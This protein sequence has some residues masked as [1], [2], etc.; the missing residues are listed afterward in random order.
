MQRIVTAELMDDPAAHRDE[1]ARSLAYIRG[2]NRLLG[3]TR[4]LLRHLHRW[5]QRWPKNR[6]ITLL[7]IGTGS[8]DIPLAARTWADQRGFDL[9]ITAVDLH[10]T[11]LDLAREHVAGRE[12]IT[13]VQED[14]RRLTDRFDPGSFDYAHAGL[15]LHHL[16]FIEVLTVLRIMD[17][18]ARAGIV[19]N[20]LVRSRLSLRVAELL[21]IGQPNMVRHDARASIR[22]GFTR[23]E[24]LDFAARTGIDYGRYRR[25]LFHRF[26]F[27]GE[28]HGAWG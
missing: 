28:K 14:A 12:G 20:D 10:P 15:F 1:L 4:G 24:V 11:T 8:A 7:D 27:A 3:G 2:V 13:L 9:H 26:T 6:P 16:P 21:L 23:A 22:A 18:L 5:S 25:L 19:W 17:R